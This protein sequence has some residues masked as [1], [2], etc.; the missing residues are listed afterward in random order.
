MLTSKNDSPNKKN[1]ENVGF[2]FD[3]KIIL[4]YFSMWIELSINIHEM[5][6]I[7]FTYWQKISSIFFLLKI[8]LTNLM[9]NHEESLEEN[10]KI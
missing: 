4:I 5:F 6:S 3:K 2:F 9:D 7:Q 10:E 8:V 1:E